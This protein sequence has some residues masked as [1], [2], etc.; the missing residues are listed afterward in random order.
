MCLLGSIHTTS[1]VSKLYYRKSIALS[2]WLQ[3][4][5]G[6]QGYKTVVMLNST[7][8]EI[9]PILLRR[10]TDAHHLNGPLQLIDTFQAEIA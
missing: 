1:C 7:E 4:I 3:L 9:S 10:H 5:P 8:H 6:P 2:K